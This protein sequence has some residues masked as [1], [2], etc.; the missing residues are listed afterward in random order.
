VHRG[1]QV[2]LGHLIERARAAD[3]PS[4]VV[5]FEPHPLTVLRPGTDVPVLTPIGLKAQL[6]E[7][8]GIDAL[9]IVPFTHAF[10]RLEPDEFAHHM[11][12]ANMHAARVVV[13]SNF[14]FGHRAAGDVDLLAQLGQQYGFVVDRIDLAGSADTT[15]SSTYIRSCIQAGDVEAAAAAL[16]RPHRVEGVVVRGDRRGRSLGFPTAN[17]EPLPASSVPGDGVYA[18]WLHL[19][20]E[21]IAAA[22]SIGT[23]PTFEGQARRV[24]A[25]AL[26]REDLDLYGAR[27][28]F[29]FVARLRDTLKFATVDALV[30]QMADDVKRCREILTRS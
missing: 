29:S 21:P 10:S 16:S 19:D 28:G 5:T 13:G 18:G 24:E 9:C 4:V 1:H 20:Q 25:Y 17:L 12:V 8:F 27:A 22:I 14:R 2:T 26:D 7:E 3:L 11:L 15:W 6:L 30:A 23:N